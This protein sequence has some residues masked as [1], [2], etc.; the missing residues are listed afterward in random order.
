MVKMQPS[1]M[2]SSI[3]RIVDAVRMLVSSGSYLPERSRKISAMRMNRTLKLWIAANRVSTPASAS[4]T[5]RDTRPI[6][7][8]PTVPTTN[9][10]Q[11]ANASRSTTRETLAPDLH[12]RLGPAGISCDSLFIGTKK[13][14]SLKPLVP[15]QRCRLPILLYYSLHLSHADPSQSERSSLICRLPA[16]A[17][18]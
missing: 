8:T 2:T 10:Q 4:A 7:T 18:R 6:S 17:L 13:A 15:I 1:Q 11:F 14:E 5:G 9:Q 16:T 12:L 3:T